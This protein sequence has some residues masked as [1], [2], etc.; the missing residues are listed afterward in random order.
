M[1][2]MSA[3]V[4]GVT[5]YNT[6]IVSFFLF[7]L[8][9]FLLSASTQRVHSVYLIFVLVRYKVNHIFYREQF[10]TVL[11]YELQSPF[12]VIWR[13]VLLAQHSLHKFRNWRKLICKINVYVLLGL[14]Y[15]RQLSVSFI[16][17]YAYLS[18]G[19]SVGWGTA[20]QFGRSRF[21]LPMV[22]LEF[23]IDIILPTALWP[24]GWLS[25]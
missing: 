6:V 16:N 19:S 1:V 18:R 2:A 7:T 10:M 22:S 15:F 12:V 23:F 5:S 24:W 21:R 14:I 17:T 3:N 11:T 13:N 8:L 4:H 25:L 9:C 20:L